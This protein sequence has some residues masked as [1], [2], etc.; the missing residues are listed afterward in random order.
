MKRSVMLAIAMAFA[1]PHANAE[2]VRLAQNSVHQ[3]KKDVRQDTKA[4]DRDKEAY[5]RDRQK[6]VDD[7]QKT[8]KD[9]YALGGAKRDAAYA[10]AARKRYEQLAQA[11]AAKGDR[12]GAEANRRQ[13]EEQRHKF[14]EAQHKI[15]E[16]QHAYDED[17]RREQA[18]KDHMTRAYNN[19]GTD[20]RRLNADQQNLNRTKAQRDA[21]K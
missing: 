14:E 5:A 21:D 10:D 19:A 17:L 15:G 8:V 16:S 11:A 13:A 18:D 12:A 20:Q 7:H 9:Y 4:V 6:L 1:L 3:D 2:G